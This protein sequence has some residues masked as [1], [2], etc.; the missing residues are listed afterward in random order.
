MFPEPDIKMVQRSSSLKSQRTTPRKDRNSERR[1]TCL[2]VLHPSPPIKPDDFVIL[3]NKEEERDGEQ[4]DKENSMK[5]Y[6]I[7]SETVEVVEGT[8]RKTKKSGYS[9]YRLL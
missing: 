1:K 3:L 4:S 7:G 9:L 5:V 8:V 6:Q 2:P